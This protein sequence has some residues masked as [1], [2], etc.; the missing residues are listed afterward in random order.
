V[1]APD[2]REVADALEER[3]AAQ[4]YVD[5]W[6]GIQTSYS[7]FH[8][9]LNEIIQIYNG[10]W[11]VIW[12]DGETTEALPKIFNAV[13]SSAKDRAK[14]VAAITPSVRRR[15]QK[16]GD[17]ARK[18][19]DKIE[20]IA[21]D[22]LRRSR[23]WGHTTQ[24]WA[25]DA[26]AGGLMVCKV[27]MDT[28]MPKDQ[29]YPTFKHIHPARSFPDPVFAPGPKVDTMIVSYVEKLRTLKKRFPDADFGPFHRDPNVS[30]D[31][32]TV[33]EFYDDKWMVVVVS[34]INRGYNPN[35]TGKQITLAEVEHGLGCTPFAIGTSPSMDGSY[36]GDFYGVL[37]VL[38]YTNRLRTL[39]LDDAIHKVYPERLIYDVEDPEQE[40]PGADINLQRPESRYEYVQ[41]PNQPFS[42]LQIMRDLMGEIRAGVTLPPS[43]SGDP[44]ESIIS[45]AGIG[46]ASGQFQLSAASIQKD[47]IAPM[48]QHGLYI[49]G[50]WDR[51]WGDDEKKPVSKPVGASSGSFAENYTP[52]KD[53]PEYLEVEIEYGEAAGL[54]PVN[55]NVLVLQQKGAGLISNRTAMELSPFVEDPQREEKQIT[56]ELLIAAQLAGLQ[57]EAVNGMLSSDQLAAI[58]ELLDQDGM[59]LSQA[60]RE[61]TARAPLAAPAATPGAAP[62]APGLAGAAAPTNSQ[63]GLPPVEELFGQAV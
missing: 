63:A 13:E 17:T 23:V 34:A 58:D 27:D 24:R 37:G 46:A 39:M 25:L 15:I 57:Q 3:R 11:G 47:L 26:M 43:R 6:R 19:K 53:I 14:V 61:V 54:D 18:Q 1:A 40:G 33:I 2:G 38:N 35:K 28:S 36:R 7:E 45:A 56:R 55:H 41:Q 10:N 51:V 5:A 9:R 62:E 4:Y 30:A 21:A 20:R 49:A 32:G 52:T 16:P 22:W 44:N 31:E 60:I 29:R 50:R 48:L 8:E 59:S 42:N 12:P